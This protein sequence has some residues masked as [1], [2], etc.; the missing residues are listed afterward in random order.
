MPRGG[1]RYGAGRPGWHRKAEASL[2]L[3]VRRLA[4]L[5]YLR[6][7]MS[8]GWT[9]RDGYGDVVGT[10]AVAVPDACRV[11][12]S[13][14][15]TPYAGEPQR[16]CCSVPLCRTRCNYGA[17]RVWFTCPE[18]DRRCALIYFGAPG[19]QYGCRRCAVVAYAS[20]SEDWIDRLYRKQ[21]KLA[22][23]M[24][25]GADDCI[26][27]RPKGMHQ[28]TYGRLTEQFFEIEEARDQAIFYRIEQ[29]LQARCR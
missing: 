13:Y 24:A 3:D 29:R 18:C 21:Q 28:S 11:L 7:G 20:Q 17:S 22:K 10:I 26:W 1:L 19:G 8:Y 12:L 2:S 15:W 27:R 9:W 25:V 23:R 5:G 16:V 14:R 4:R 6:A